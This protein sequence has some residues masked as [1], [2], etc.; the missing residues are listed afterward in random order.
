VKKTV[1][2]DGTFYYSW[3]HSALIDHDI[4]FQ[5]EYAHFSVT[6]PVT[7]NDVLT[8]KY[9]VGPAIVWTIP[10]LWIHTFLRGDGYT[11]P[12]QFAIGLTT[13]LYGITG[14]LL[15]YRMLCFW[16]TPIIASLTTVLIAL[17][18]HLFF[19]GAIDPVNSHA[20]S[21]FAATLFITCVVSKK[22]WMSG[23]VLGIIMLMRPQDG[24]Y[25]IL[26]LFLFPP[27]AWIRVGVGFLLTFLPQLVAWT[28]FTGNPFLSPYFLGGEHYTFLSPH[29]IDV[30]FSLK[31]GLFVYT[32]LV[33]IAAIGYFLR[34]KQDVQQYKVP[35]IIIL[36]L[37]LYLV[38]S[39]SSWDQ[40]ASFSG[41]M[42]VGV[43]PLLAFPLSV[44]MTSLIKKVLTPL[45]VVLTFLIPLGA[46]NMILTLYFLLTHA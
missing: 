18:T 20:L 21:F 36:L 40:G 14:L 46:I 45:L 27:R 31:N 30:L 41:R 43:L 25:A 9:A 8:N 34:W 42:L 23:V 1:Y 28:A 39:W 5:N 16:T 24:I 12:Y 19:Y 32:P 29:I 11:F 35:S 37:S 13:V 22:A 26:I 33:L 15:L 17:A 7:A 38:S 10:F 6:Q 2:G 4:Q 44:L 3:L